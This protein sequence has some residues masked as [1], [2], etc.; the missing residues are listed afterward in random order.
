MK[1][2][3]S[4]SLMSVTVDHE[5][6]ATEKMG[7]KTVGQV[8][9]H[10]QRGNRLVTNLLIDGRAP[11]L[12]ILSTVRTSPLNGHTVY[13]E[14]AEPREMA[15]NVLEEVEEQLDDTDTLRNDAADLLQRNQL[16]KAME[17]LSGCFAVWQT[18]QESVLKIGQL[19]R[20]NLD[21]VR[22]NGQTLSAVLTHFADQLRQIKSAIEHRD[23]VT[24]GDILAYEADETSLQWR[25]ALAA[26]RDVVS[27]KQSS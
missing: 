5:P 22:V 1:Q 12:D 23:F 25:N 16:G 26:V 2:S 10:L 9:S 7:L 27:L 11:D 20:I 8:L 21:V 15:L 13:I 6:L 18:A 24:L 17:K 3:K 19:L 14:T 4:G